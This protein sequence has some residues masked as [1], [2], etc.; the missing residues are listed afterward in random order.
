MHCGNA[1]RRTRS[2]PDTLHEPRLP[3]HIEEQ[4]THILGVG[5]QLPILALDN[6][7]FSPPCSMY[8]PLPADARHAVKASAGSE[9][10]RLPSL[11]DT[12][13]K[14]LTFRPEGRHGHIPQGDS[15]LQGEG[16]EVLPVLPDTGYV[17]RAASPACAGHSPDSRCV[18]DR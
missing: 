17:A 13:V 6:T 2:L 1:A 4:N 5:C 15:V 10:G 7:T 11:S 9:T 12:Q 18:Q 14:R 16:R 3:G 8:A